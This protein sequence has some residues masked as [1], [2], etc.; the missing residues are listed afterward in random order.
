MYHFFS[1]LTDNK[2]PVIFLKWQ[3]YRK[4]AIDYISPNIDFLGYQQNDF[5]T[6]KISLSELIHPKDLL[7]FQTTLAQ[8]VAES[9]KTTEKKS[10]HGEFRIYSSNFD[11]YWMHYYISINRDNNESNPHFFGYFIDNTEHRKAEQAIEILARFPDENL[12]PVIRVINDGSLVYANEP[13]LKL[14]K[15]WQ[16]TTKSPQ[17]TLLSGIISQVDRTD[18]KKEVEVEIGQKIYLFTCTPISNTNC[19]YLYA[20]DITRLKQTEEEL[21]LASIVYEASIEGIMITDPTGTIQSVNPA[22]TAITGYTPQEAI[23][24]NPRILKSNRHDTDFYR[25]MWDSIKQTGKWRGEIWNRRKNNETY[26][27]LL[28]INTIKDDE[29]NIKYYV[30][31]FNDIIELKQKESEIQY[32]AYHD[33]LT[34][35]PNRELFNDR[36]KLEINR[37]SRSG[38]KLGVMFLDLDNFKDINDS[39]GHVVGDYLL[40]HVARRLLKCVRDVDTVARIGGD[41]FTILLPQISDPKEIVLVIQRIL[42]IFKEPFTVQEHE[43]YSTAS[44][45]I[46]I[47]PTDGSD[48]IELLKHA[49]LA[50]Y[51]A[52]DHGK[53]SYVFFA[54]DMNVQIKKRLKL[55]NQLRRAVK[56]NQFLLHYQPLV[57]MKTGYTVGVEALV[58]WNHPALGIVAPND[59][60]PLAEETGAIFRLGD[61]I[62]ETSCKQTLIWQRKGLSPIFTSV[63]VSSRQFFRKDFLENLKNILENVGLDTSSLTLQITENSIMRNRDEIIQVMNSL[64]EIGIKLSIDDFGVGYSSLNYLKC[65]PLDTLKIDQSF[66]YDIPKDHNSM[67]ITKSIITLAK[68]LNL[69]VLAEGVENK[70]QLK[71][72]QDNDCD[73]M[74]GYY[75]SPP[76]TPDEILHIIKSKRNLYHLDN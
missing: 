50:M 59:F 18:K 58:R 6:G 8:L 47:F 46:S 5:L 25:A 68:N 15:Q 16:E 66:I 23:G 62:L 22:F 48:S 36:L 37:A 38:L 57:D 51:H 71:F 30:A 28:S 34:T 2:S 7:L 52:K 49:D 40:Q 53:N 74:Q 64:K 44:I 20:T 43:L 65:F 14:L 17:K 73:L 45:G 55:E 70:E 3:D 72:L 9:T 67:A 42:N 19:I 76:V 61:W 69:K 54:H 26:P 10:L 56:K 13:G 4:P 63:N 60:I 21:K 31:V 11:T 32:R 75:F 27:E 29:G 41:E 33:P 24:R 12:N 39:L 1:L 35:L